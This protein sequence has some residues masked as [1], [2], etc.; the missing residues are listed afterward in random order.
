M[1][2]LAR[3]LIL[4]HPGLATLFLARCRLLTGIYNQP[5]GH[6]HNGCQRAAFA[7]RA[8]GFIEAHTS[9]PWFIY[10]ACHEPHVQVILADES[11]ALTRTGSDDPLRQKYLGD[12][13]DLDAAVGIVLATLRALHLRMPCSGT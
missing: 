13:H 10:F 12:L 9:Q 7:T 8:A 2:T 5:F 6:E 4:L 11:A 1:I 3:H